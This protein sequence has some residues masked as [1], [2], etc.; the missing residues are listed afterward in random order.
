MRSNVVSYSILRYD[1]VQSGMW[2]SASEACNTA[3][4]IGW[5]CRR[6]DMFVGE[7]RSTGV[8]NQGYSYPFQFFL[9]DRDRAVSEV[10]LPSCT[11]DSTEGHNKFS[12]APLWKSQMIHEE[13]YSEIRLD[14]LAVQWITNCVTWT[15]NGDVCSVSLVDRFPQIILFR[16][17]NL[18]PFWR[19][20]FL[21]Y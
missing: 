2:I 5:V 15:H 19:P 1:T 21:L 17:L 10:L 11:V 14:R 7:R 6:D 18:W 12:R 20:S 4:L 3:V 16:Y 9:E 13:C 8:S